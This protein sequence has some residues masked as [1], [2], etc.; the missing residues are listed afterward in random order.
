MLQVTELLGQHFE[1]DKYDEIKDKETN[2]L[3][4]A[5]LIEAI[6]SRSDKDKNQLPSLSQAV[7]EKKKNESPQ[8]IGI[9][10]PDCAKKKA[11][12]RNRSF[13]NANASS[14]G[15]HRKRVPRAL[16]MEDT[17]DSGNTSSDQSKKEVDTWE[18]VK[19]QP[20]CVVCGMVFASEGKLDT[21]IKYSS[22]HAANLKKIEAMEKG[23]KS[24]KGVLNEQEEESSRCRV[25]YTGSKHFW[26]T[27]DFLDITIYL[28]IEAKCLEVI[29][30]DTNASFEYPRIYLDENKIYGMITEKAVW[31]K[32]EAMKVVANGKKFKKELA[33]REVLFQEE[34]RVLESSFVLQRLKL[35]ADGKAPS[36]AKK[37][38]V[39]D[40]T[41]ATDEL[42]ASQNAE[43]LKLGVLS[44]K[45]KGVGQKQL[46]YI[47]EVYDDEQQVEFDNTKVVVTPVLLQRRRHSSDQEIKDAFDSIEA[48]QNDIRGMTERAAGIANKVHSGVE[49]FNLRVRKS[50]D[51]STESKPR[52]KWAHAISRILRRNHVDNMAKHL[53]SFGDK[54]YIPPP[55]DD[56]SP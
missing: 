24:T 36:P 50:A 11:K 12:Q 35:S 34:K 7:T 19:S 29:A 23:S 32:V 20:S 1:K 13:E 53:Q 55:N 6:K 26:R 54:Y 47:P 44:P 42:L 27:Q 9:Q 41:K 49:E 38:S 31:D 17:P 4:R 25:L 30:F 15:R 2:L 43:M 8:K 48:M 28:H 18:S 37:V 21:H 46:Y 40:L 16:S 5:V 33:P 10:L 22:V 3:S 14:P 45:R 52:Q 56:I 39:S 51:I